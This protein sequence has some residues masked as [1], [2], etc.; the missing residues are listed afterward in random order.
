MQ[1]RLADPHMT[2]DEILKKFAVRHASET[3]SAEELAVGLAAW[4]ADNYERLSYE[5]VALLIQIGGMLM[6]EPVETVEGE[7]AP[8]LSAPPY[9]DAATP[10]AS[11]DKIDDVK[12]R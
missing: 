12:P 8:L 7:A 4:L 9:D 2:S 1:P 5:G 10:P 6:P 3:A 11:V